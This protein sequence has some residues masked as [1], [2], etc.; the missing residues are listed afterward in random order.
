MGVEPKRCEWANFC[1]VMNLRSIFVLFWRHVMISAL[2]VLASVVVDRWNDCGVHIYGWSSSLWAW[3]RNYYQ[4]SVLFSAALLKE[5]AC[6]LKTNISPESHSY[7]TFGR[8]SKSKIS[9][10]TTNVII[11]VNV[12]FMCFWMPSI[13][14]KERTFSCL[15]PKGNIKVENTKYS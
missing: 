6:M 10:V 8:Q 12:A 1:R 11:V 15:S 3:F 5:P 13:I 14:L 7:H 9:E 4:F 2:L